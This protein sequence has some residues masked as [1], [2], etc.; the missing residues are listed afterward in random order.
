MAGE[1]RFVCP[2]C[3]EETSIEARAFVRSIYPSP[4]GG[5]SVV[6]TV[7]LKCARCEHDLAKGQ[8]WIHI[9]GKEETEEE[10]CQ[11]SE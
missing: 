2:H 8:D 6:T 3:G 4:F 9:R 10:V 1:T 11:I 7:I 5:T